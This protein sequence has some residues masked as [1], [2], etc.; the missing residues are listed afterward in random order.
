MKVLYQNVCLLAIIC[1]LLPALAQRSIQDIC[2]SISAVAACNAILTLP[3][4]EIDVKQC[5]HKLFKVNGCKSHIDFNV[6]CPTIQKPF[7][8]CHEQKCVPGT[9]E[10]WVNIPCGLTMHT[11][12]INVCD[13]IRRSFPI[14]D[15]LISKSTAM[16]KCLPQ[17][18]NLGGDATISNLDNADVS[19]ATSKTLSVYA[20]LSKVCLLPCVYLVNLMGFQCFIDNGFT[21]HDDKPALEEAGKILSTSDGSIVIRAQEIDL[22]SYITF[23]EAVALCAGAGNCDSVTT[24]F[25]DYLKNSIDLMSNE[26]KSAVI[27]P[28]TN[29][30]NTVNAAVMSIDNELKGL[31]AR[32]S[33]MQLEIEDIHV[34]LCQD[35]DSCV[36]PLVVSFYKIGAI[37]QAILTVQD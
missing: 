4:G 12:K 35:V 2:S 26:L 29:L 13:K 17:V 5:R 32:L 33:A 15:E 10:V 8:T 16:C 30:V 34:Q 28:W 7:R 24:F 19:S 37:W 23:A 21:V 22:A 6:P 1:V 18:L 27:A 9:D 20:S 36:N 11:A 31:P 14:A 25:T 3:T